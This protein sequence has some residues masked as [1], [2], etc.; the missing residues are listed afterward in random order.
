MTNIATLQR[1][2]SWRGIQ[3]HSIQQYPSMT[4]MI[5]SDRQWKKSET[6]CEM[7]I[8]GMSFQLTEQQIS[9]FV[10]AALSIRSTIEENLSYSKKNSAAQKWF[11]CVAKHIAPKTHNHLIKFSSK[12]LKKERLKTVVMDT[13]LSI[14]RILEEVVKVFPT[15]KGF[16]AIQYAVATYEQ[17]KE[18]LSYFYPKNCPARWQTHLSSLNI[19]MNSLKKFYNTCGWWI[20]IAFVVFCSFY[21]FL[22]NKSISLH[23]I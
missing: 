16:R 12:S 21:L 14:A 23:S 4:C 2:N 20:F 10:L 18:R 5:V 8:V 6:P 22:N 3:T 1:L 11:V 7:G 13:C 15:G 17:T 9:S 19:N